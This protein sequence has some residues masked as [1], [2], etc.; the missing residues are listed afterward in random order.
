[1][2]MKRG[3][4]RSEP[5]RNIEFIW[6]YVYIHTQTYLSLHYQPY[7]QSYGW[8][9]F[10]LL[11]VAR[12]I[13]LLHCYFLLWLLLSGLTERVSVCMCVCVFFSYLLTFKVLLFGILGRV[14]IQF[15]YNVDDL[16]LLQTY[17]VYGPVYTYS[18]SRSI[19]NASC[20]YDSCTK[21][22]F[23][24]SIEVSRRVINECINLS[25]FAR[26]NWHCLWRIEIL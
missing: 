13:V 22:R 24:W 20:V 9:T 18:F 25:F 21:C 19:C 17:N 12:C 10:L 5:E 8:V 6:M 3:S 4:G 2:A 14:Y 11:H 26:R 7:R 1:M 15:D 16:D 23:T